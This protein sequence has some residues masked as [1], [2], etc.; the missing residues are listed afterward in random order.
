MRRFA[1]PTLDKLLDDPEP[2]TR[3]AALAILA[4]DEKPTPR[5]IAALLKMIA[6]KD[7]PQDWRADAVERIR[8][9][10]P[11]NLAQATP[12]LIRQLGDQNTDVR[13]TA[14]ELLMAIIEDTLA[15]MPVPAS[16]K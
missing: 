8:E 2:G 7:L 12:A 4:I 6:S 13:R 5:V 16:G 3:H 10:S 11:K 14:A 1:L 9:S 15:E